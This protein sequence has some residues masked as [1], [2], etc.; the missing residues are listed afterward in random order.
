MIFESPQIVTQDGNGCH[1]H[2]K[3]EADRCGHRAADSA[4]AMTKY[5]IPNAK[6]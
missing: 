5:Q 4:C 6:E 3:D 2:G 1:E